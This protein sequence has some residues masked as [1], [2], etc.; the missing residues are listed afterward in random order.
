MAR[1]LSLRMTRPT[2]L[3]RRSG[4]RRRGRPADTDSAQTRANILAAA[5]RL[6]GE[7]GYDGV[8]MT[9]IA[10]AAGLTVASSY[11]YFPSKLELFKAVAISS[12]ERFR[13]EVLDRV[14]THEN[15]KDRMHGYLSAY[16]ALYETEPEV[17]RFLAVAFAEVTYD[18]RS[19]DRP[20]GAGRAAELESAL[21]PPAAILFKVSQNAVARGELHDRLGP[22]DADAFFRAMT[23]AISATLIRDP[24]HFLS[25][26]DALDLFIDG[27]LFR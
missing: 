7:R 27:E 21:A 5:Q 9:D 13:A 8:S 17:L 24:A 1:V 15:V 23:S 25:F 10:E 4:P 18:P 3:R 20:E 2:P 11:H 16:R 6:F 12:A 22:Q 14:L 26:L 19:I